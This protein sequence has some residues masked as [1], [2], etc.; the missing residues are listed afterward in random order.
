MDSNDDDLRFTQTWC[1]GESMSITCTEDWTISIEC[2]FYGLDPTLNECGIGLLT[3]EPV[4]YLASSQTRIDSLCSGKSTCSIGD[5]TD[6]FSSDRDPC[7]DL[8][9]QLHIKW[10]CIPPVPTTTTITETST[11]SLSTESG[12]I[13]NTT[14]KFIPTTDFN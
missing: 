13:K 4:C 6:F 5:I 9:K 10:K 3:Y 2:A 11:S 14:T 1:D 12:E 8:D 7:V